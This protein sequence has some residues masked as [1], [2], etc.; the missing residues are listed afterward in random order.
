VLDGVLN[1]GALS[2]FSVHSA[3]YPGFESRYENS[4]MPPDFSAETKPRGLS[5]RLMYLLLVEAMGSY[6]TAWNGA[7]DWSQGRSL[8]TMDYPASDR[9]FSA[10]CVGFLTP[11]LHARFGRAARQPRRDG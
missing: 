6:S 4:R 1:F 7:G 11:Q 10:P 5:A 9:H 8:W 2:A 3:S